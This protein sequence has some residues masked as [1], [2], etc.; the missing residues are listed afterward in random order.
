MH[1]VESSVP[2]LVAPA[3]PLPPKDRL[4]VKEFLGTGPYSD[5]A[6]LISPFEEVIFL[7]RPEKQPIRQVYSKGFAPQVAQAL[8][9]GTSQPQQQQLLLG[10]GDN[11][12]NDK[13][14]ERHEVPE[15]S[16]RRDAE[17]MPFCNYQVY[18]V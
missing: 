15:R 11:Q 6:T 7:W 17:V 10:L 1:L 3:H 14:G 13:G 5:G 16:D 4:P 2:P 18:A 9:P 8:A 12:R